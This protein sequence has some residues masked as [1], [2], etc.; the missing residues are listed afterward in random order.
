[1]YC[2]EWN[3][4][5]KQKHSLAMDRTR[6]SWHMKK[7]G[8]RYSQYFNRKYKRQGHLFQNR[9]LS[10]PIDDERYLLTVLRYIL[11]NPR[12][13]GICAAEYEWSSY[14]MYVQPSSFED[15]A[16]FRELIVGQRGVCRFSRSA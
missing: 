8:V 4:V 9:Y 3:P 6:I 11:N 16:M 12:K 7:L 13:A 14:R 1:M 15:T 2:E 10:E 5:R